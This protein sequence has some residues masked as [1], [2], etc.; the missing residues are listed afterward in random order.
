MFELPDDET[1]KESVK[2][3]MKAGRDFEEEKMSERCSEA[4]STPKIN[5]RPNV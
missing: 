3:P 4:D 1:D 5:V 2:M